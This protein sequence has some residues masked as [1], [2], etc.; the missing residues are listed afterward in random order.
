M[1]DAIQKFSPFQSFIE[2]SFFTKLSQLKLDDFKLDTSEQQLVG[3]YP[4]PP[5]LTRFNDRPVINLDHNSFDHN[6]SP[7]GC[8]TVPGLLH[9]VN[10]VE[11]FKNSDKQ[12]LLKEWYK[13][14]HIFHLYCY[15]DLKKY[16]FYYM[17]AIPTKQCRWKVL[18]SS[19]VELQLEDNLQTISFEKTFFKSG[20]DFIYLDAS[21]ANNPSSLLMRW[22]PTEGSSTV[23]VYQSSGSKKYTLTPI[24]SANNAFTG[25][26]RSSTGKLAPKIADL[27]SLIDPHQLA[28]QAVDL[29][30]KLMK[31]RIAPDINLDII[32][33]QRVL[34]LGAG[35]LGSYVARALMG[36]GVR[37]ITFVDNGRVSYS[38]PVRQPLYEFNDCQ[39]SDGQGSPKAKTAAEALKRI[40]PDV[41]AEGHSLEVPMVG[42]ET[43]KENYDKLKVLITNN[44]AI[45]LL[46]DS[47]ESR[48]LPTVMGKAANKIV[49]NAA[50]G[51]DSFL[52]M[53][54]GTPNND[55]GCYYC[56]DVVAPSDSLSDRTLDQMC[57]V[58][59]P[60]SAM[61][62]SAL[63]VE[64][65]ISILQHPQ[66]GDALVEDIRMFSTPHQIR[67]FLNSFVQQ[68]FQSP[69]FPQCSACSPSV[70][71]QYLQNDWEFISRCIADANYLE[72]VSGLSA[73]K[74]A[75][76]EASNKLIDEL[77]DAD[78][79]DEWFD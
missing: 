12:A 61:L 46:M 59:R 11:E 10:T 22:L 48:W 17:M 20:D 29:N 30:L 76:E 33:Q 57:T 58:T 40:F 3:F 24:S 45:F 62:A 27:G 32:R 67:G 75:A 78:I 8:V 38:N 47:R 23:V 18:E 39:G 26:E 50:L 4:S 56:N 1:T 77:N 2:S 7:S 49:I 73:V 53:R 41:K 51:F 5:N 52:V 6:Y 28:S 43:S 42:H 68:K 14:D 65:Y 13:S 63:A 71:Q 55:L 72:S 15:A 37:R 70:Q 19:P 74:Q 9:L 66:R 54:H 69:A 21:N 64:L 36:W 34:L 31:W 79:D 60:G 16:K 25:W 35:T 44:D